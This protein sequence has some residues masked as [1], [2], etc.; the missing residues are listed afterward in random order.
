MKRELDM[1]EDIK[2]LLTKMELNQRLYMEAK[3]KM[4]ADINLVKH[5]DETREGTRKCIRDALE[6]F[7][8]RKTSRV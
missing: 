8:Y 3:L 6:I 1:L 4:E 7:Q 5:P 2:H